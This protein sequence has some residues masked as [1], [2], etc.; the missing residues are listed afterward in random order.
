[1]ELLYE[2]HRKQ[3]AITSKTGKYLHEVLLPKFRGDL[4][5]LFLLLRVEGAFRRKSSYIPK[6]E[7]SIS[8]SE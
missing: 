3:K 8:R 1:M 4:V 6:Q 5:C 2:N 7:W